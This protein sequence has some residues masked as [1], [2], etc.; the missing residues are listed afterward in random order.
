MIY[1]EWMH[2]F[3]QLCCHLHLAIG[4]S[5]EGW[6]KTVAELL[7]TLLPFVVVSA[8]VGFA[9]GLLIDLLGSGML[10]GSCFGLVF[11]YNNVIGLPLVCLPFLR[12]IVHC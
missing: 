4:S 8:N 11:D 12:A 5:F 2:Y 9:F 10:P 3:H 1:C 6:K 7:Q